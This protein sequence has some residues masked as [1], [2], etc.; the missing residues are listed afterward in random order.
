MT[1][2]KAPQRSVKLS[3]VVL[4]A[5]LATLAGG[6]A[7]DGRIRLGTTGRLGTQQGRHI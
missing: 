1:I 3:L 6:C 5:L 4:T 2:F 7:R